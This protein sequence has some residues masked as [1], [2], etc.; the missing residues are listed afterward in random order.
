MQYHIV[1]QSNVSTTVW[2][3]AEKS[4]DFCC[5]TWLSTPLGWQQDHA[6]VLSVLFREDSTMTPYDALFG[7]VRER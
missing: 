7:A 5:L 4:D 3:L 6:T 1:A 2:P